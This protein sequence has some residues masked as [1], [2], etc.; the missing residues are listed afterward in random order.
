[1]AGA[2]AM[3]ARIRAWESRFVCSATSGGIARFDWRLARAF[4]GHGGKSLDMEVSLEGFA[5]ARAI[6]HQ[7]MADA[8]LDT[9]NTLGDPTVV[10]PNK[11]SRASTTDR[12]LTARLPPLSYQLCP[13][14]RR[15][16]TVLVRANS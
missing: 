6:A 14:L 2:E 5:A 16:E 9:V 1:M 8:A 12:A 13:L 3:P 10:T 11:G 4:I 7:V 15:L